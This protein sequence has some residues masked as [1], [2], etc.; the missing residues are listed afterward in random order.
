MSEYRLMNKLRPN[1]IRKVYTKEEGSRNI[2]NF[3]FAAASYGADPDEMFEDEDLLENTPEGMG[4]VART[5]LYLASVI[6]EERQSFVV[7]HDGGKAKSTLFVS[8]SRIVGKTEPVQFDNKAEGFGMSQNTNG[9]RSPYGTL[10]RQMG[11]MSNPELA[12]RARPTSPV[13]DTRGKDKLARSPGPKV[14]SPLPLGHR[15]SQHAQGS[16]TIRPN[17]DSSGSPVPSAPS[18]PKPFVSRSPNYSPKMTRV[19]TPESKRG[20]TSSPFLE[21]P[22]IE[23][24]RPAVDIRSSF[25]ESNSPPLRAPLRLP[26]TTSNQRQ[27]ATSIV[28]NSSLM[29]E[30]TAGFSSLLDSRSNGFGTMRT[31]TTEATSPSSGIPSFSRSEAN[32]AAKAVLLTESPQATRGQLAEIGNPMA[33]RSSLAPPP[34]EDVVVNSGPVRT[35][36]RDRR[37]SEAAVD[38]TRVNEEPD[39]TSLAPS[40]LLLRRRDKILDNDINKRVAR[41]W[42]DDFDSALDTDIKAI[43]ELQKELMGGDNSSNTNLEVK[44]PPVLRPIAIPSRRLD[45]PPPLLSAEEARTRPILVPRRSKLFSGDN[46]MLPSPREGLVLNG[47]D[48]SPSSGAESSG[49]PAP[50]PILRRPT[51]RNGKRVYVPKGSTPPGSEIIDRGLV[52]RASPSLAGPSPLST[53][54]PKESPHIPFPRRTSAEWGPGPSRLPTLPSSSE[55]LRQDA[56]EK[57]EA[58]PAVEPQRPGY[59]RGRHQSEFDSQRRQKPRPG[60]MDEIGARRSR[61][62]SML[63]GV[64]SEERLAQSPPP[65]RGQI[66]RRVLVVKEEGQPAVR[67]VS[68]AFKRLVRLMLILIDPSLWAIVLAR[69]S[70]GRSTVP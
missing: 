24:R 54:L 22:R 52:Q 68:L 2:R 1:I 70:L 15:P 4:S 43:D 27:S 14:G 40:K 41:K 35:S 34:P 23:A 17:R 13:S 44:P 42:P 38:L 9:G 62:E 3:R 29:T 48:G 8:A 55:T 7:I 31:N 5:L 37:S 20:R 25:G 39:E 10:S 16:S 63:E 32:E 49:A 12:S 61:I 51:S 50:P 19:V 33:D 26:P 66:P 36:K 18:S 56:E 64:R 67:Y 30:S 53:S 47:R 6:E 45:G 57:K 28:T 65:V 46:G 69:G 11:V 60:S 21:K 59:P 58:R